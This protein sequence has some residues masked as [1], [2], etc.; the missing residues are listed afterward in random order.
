MSPYIPPPYKLAPD[1][2]H[3]ELAAKSAV[4]LWDL[5]QLASSLGAFISGDFFFPLSSL[6]FPSA[7]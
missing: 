7:V 2:S 4:F 5:R 3:V 6:L 1:V